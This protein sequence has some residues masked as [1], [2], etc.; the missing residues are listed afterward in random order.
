[1]AFAPRKSETC[2][3]NKCCIC[4]KTKSNCRK[5]FND[6]N[7]FGWV[8]QECVDKHNVPATDENLDVA[9]IFRCTN[10][11]KLFWIDGNISPCFANDLTCPE[12]C[13]DCCDKTK[14]FQKCDK[15]EYML[16][17]CKHKHLCKCK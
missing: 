6:D 17:C 13:N 14:I 7:T 8:C 9:D 10:C 12:L 3:M 1:M 4:K 11:K 15:C 16:L 5:V 2:L